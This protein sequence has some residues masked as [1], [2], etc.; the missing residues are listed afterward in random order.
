MV[1]KTESG[2]DQRSTRR[3]PYIVAAGVV[4]FVCAAIGLHLYRPG[5]VIEVGDTIFPL[6][7]RHELHE[8]LNW[9]FP[10]ELGLAWL[11]TSWA[12]TFVWPIVGSAFLPLGLVQA[13]RFAF[14][15]AAPALA[16]AYALRVLIG[17]NVRAAAIAGV[18][19]VTLNLRSVAQLGSSLENVTFIGSAFIACAVCDGLIAG[20][21][22]RALLWIAAAAFVLAPDAANPPYI[23]IALLFGAS[24][25]V[26]VALAYRPRPAQILQFVGGALGVGFLMSLRWI[27]PLWLTLHAYPLSALG[28]GAHQDFS[29]VNAGAS[30]SNVVRNIPLWFW[31]DPHYT[32]L[33]VLLT[34]NGWL[35]VAA[36]APFLALIVAVGFMRSRRLRFI[37][38]CACMTVGWWFLGKGQQPPLVMLSAAIEHL[39]LM[40]LFRD[41][42]KFMI[43]ATLYLALTIGI[44]AGVP[45]GNRQLSRLLLILTVIG[46]LGS[47]WILFSRVVFTNP[48]ATPS[49]YVAVP[50]A[51]LGVGRELAAYARCRTN[52]LP[53]NQYYEV[54]YRWGMFGDDTQFFDEL[55]EAPLVHRAYVGYT[56]DPVAEF[57]TESY[58]S[59][60]RFDPV[61]RADLDNLYGIGNVL[62][63]NDVQP[64]IGVEK[65]TPRAID[66]VAP[67]A[68]RVWA[69]GGLTLYSRGCNTFSMTRWFPRAVWSRDPSLA[70]VRSLQPLALSTRFLL[71]QAQRK[72]ALASHLQ[73]QSEPDLPR[74]TPSDVV[75][76]DDPLSTMA[77]ARL[78]PARY[79]AVARA[80]SSDSFLIGFGHGFVQHAPSKPAA[81]IVFGRRSEIIS[82]GRDGSPTA[83][84]A[85]FTNESSYNAIA[86]V[87]APILAARQECLDV[88]EGDVPL[89]R[90]RIPSPGR[91]LVPLALRLG[92][93]PN[94][95][96]LETALSCQGAQFASLEP[97]AWGPMIA[98]E[99]VISRRL[100]DLPAAEVHQHAGEL[101]IV[102]GFD[103]AVFRTEIMLPHPMADP[104]ADL[105]YL[106]DKGVDATVELGAHIVGGSCVADVTAASG[107]PGPLPLD[108]RSAFNDLRRRAVL[109]S[110]CREM[111]WSALRV[112]ALDI[113]VVAQSDQSSLGVHLQ[114]LRVSERF[115]ARSWQP[116]S[117]VERGRPQ[118]RDEVRLPGY[119][120]RVLWTASVPSAAHLNQDPAVRLILN[121]TCKAPTWGLRY[122]VVSNTESSWID[123]FPIAS[124][125]RPL[126]SLSVTHLPSGRALLLPRTMIR[127]AMMPGAAPFINDGVVDRV[128]VLGLSPKGAGARG[129][130]WQMADAEIGIGGIARSAYVHIGSRQFAFPADNRPHDIPLGRLSGTMTVRLQGP[131]R[132]AAI[133]NNMLLQP[134]LPLRG[135]FTGF[136]GR[137]AARGWI[138]YDQAAEHDW[139]L[140]QSRRSMAPLTAWG[141]L[142]AYP[143]V[144]GDARISFAPE[145]WRA[146][147]ELI[148][149]LT[150]ALVI[151]AAASESF[152]RT[153][154]D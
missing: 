41:A 150:F 19:T 103:P 83:Q 88:S 108:V 79:T 149:W 82:V 4:V 151:V 105:S 74:T 92:P 62:E 119:S 69:D 91:F 85:V 11:N 5:F 49:A 146:V 34:N 96:V 141:T 121:T 115:G 55:A 104:T 51:Y 29:W 144:P 1:T 80:A 50:S 53:W 40:W 109:P 8:W 42:E 58:G 10:N 93:G 107:D 64:L 37:V 123:V 125:T 75:V 61:V 57:F 117:N 135:T 147:L 153:S 98:P 90:F 26:L 15:L 102:G 114:H 100:H 17:P 132:A 28:S 48:H 122:H 154:R 86:R 127:L 43:P 18:L 39:P 70:D 65:S 72:P 99:S 54:G 21:R 2:N 139:R 23:G 71:V 73:T 95:I 87:R 78:L 116:L 56:T 33:S 101:A 13:A 137:I 22:A 66:V 145:R 134:S 3:S 20:R 60:M 16:I 27:V 67:G 81:A 106:V 124:V 77:S 46:A 140:D 126:M 31:I 143:V 9:W 136:D 112:T 118:H 97:S 76:L 63:R 84:E 129:C 36:L 130:T 89:G 30:P 148:S 44:A 47:G 7:P 12:T 59:A 32:T 45:D 24:F 133:V 6:H 113:A 14:W 25:I 142:Q 138:L 120:A 68:H 152:R 35:K 94:I 131:V 38:A 111:R 128:E 110:A 52:I